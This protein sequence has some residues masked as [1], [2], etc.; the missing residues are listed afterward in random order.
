MSYTINGTNI[1]SY[2]LET[3]TD[4]GNAIRTYYTAFP[5]TTATTTAAER[6]LPTGFLIN[7]SDVSTRDL[8]APIV[9]TAVNTTVPT[10]CNRICAMAVGAG[11]GGGQGG[12]SPFYGGGDGGDG[13]YGVVNVTP[14]SGIAV[15]P[16]APLVVVYGAAGQGGAG[17][18]ATDGGDSTISVSG[19][20]VHT[21][22]GG[23]AGAIGSRGHPAGGPTSKAPNGANGTPN[24][25]GTVPTSFPSG[26]TGFGVRGNGG[27]GGSKNGNDGSMGKVILWYKYAR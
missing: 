7:G 10:W 3:A 8:A 20:I 22:T 17:N 15:A 27:P 16:G 19:S 13:G 6:M 9:N 21:A 4:D 11:G 25:A 5:Y 2:M 1:T 24:T 23:N 14:T 12:S 18:A 26:L